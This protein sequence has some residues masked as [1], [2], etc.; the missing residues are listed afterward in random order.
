MTP[1]PAASEAPRSGRGR[2]IATALVTTI[3]ITGLIAGVVVWVVDASDDGTGSS[4]NGPNGPVVAPGAPTS[5]ALAPD[6]D[7][8]TLDGDRI[9]LSSL[10][11]R[12]V[13]VN[14]WASWC[15]PCREE[16]PLFKRALRGDNRD[17]LVIVGVIYKDITS[18]ARSFARQQHANWPLAVDDDNAT[19]I[20]YGVRA[21]PQTFFI[22]R[23]GTIEARVFG[24]TSER[25]LE[26]ELDKISPPI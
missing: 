16:F 18:D 13:V 24:I 14:F 15:H 20:A 17:D 3:A 19:A 10:R 21:V 1:S 6:F 23:D 25:E 26:R 9:S 8:Q 5:G 22:N 7:L 11:G 12:P 4:R 2:R